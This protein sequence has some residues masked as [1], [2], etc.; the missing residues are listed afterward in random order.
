MKHNAYRL[1]LT[2]TNSTTAPIEVPVGAAKVSIDINDGSSFTWGNAVADLQYSLSVLLDED[3]TD[4]TNWQAFSPVIQ[5]TS[6]TKARRA[7]GVTGTGWIRLKC[8]T[9]VSTADIGAV[10]TVRT[11]WDA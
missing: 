2:D 10:V 5:F 1:N 7:I 4:L 9:A 11:N 6:T 8:T 3:G